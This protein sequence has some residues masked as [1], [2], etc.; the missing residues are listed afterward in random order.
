MH[1]SLPVADLDEACAFYEAVFGCRVG[2]RRQDWCDVWFFGMQLTLQLRP[3]EV[4]APEQQGVRHFGVVLP[5]A[6]TW[7]EVVE[8]ATAFGSRWLSAPTRRDDPDLSG[9]L[10][11]KLAD[12]SGNVVEVKYYA[13]PVALRSVDRTDTP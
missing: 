6:Q 13:D 1:L 10:G 2:R 11:G 4:I 3:E 7:A 5:D 9:K 12:P 8:R